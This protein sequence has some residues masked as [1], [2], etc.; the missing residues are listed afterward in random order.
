MGLARLDPRPGALSIAGR[1]GRPRATR[2][3]L[4][5][6]GAARPAGQN[7]VLVRALASLPG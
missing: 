2:L 3:H 4:R 1:A 6:G 5:G 7:V